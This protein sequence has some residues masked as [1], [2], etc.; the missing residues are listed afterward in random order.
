MGVPQNPKSS[1]LAMKLFQSDLYDSVKQDGNHIVSLSQPQTI[2][3]L[4]FAILRHRA[5]ELHDLY[6][7]KITLFAEPD[8]EKADERER[9]IHDHTDFVVLNLFNV[10]HVS[11]AQSECDQNTLESAL[12]AV[13][14]ALRSTH[15]VQIIIGPI[16]L[17]VAIHKLGERV[18][19]LVL[20]HAHILCVQNFSLVQNVVK[21]YKDSKLLVLMCSFIHNN[22][23]LS[24][25]DT[26]KLVRH[27]EAIFSAKWETSAD[28][29]CISRQAPSTPVEVLEFHPIGLATCDW[30]LLVDSMLKQFCDFVLDPNLDHNN[31]PLIKP[32]P[33]LG[34]DTQS[35]K[36]PLLSLVEQLVLARSC[37]SDIIY[38]VHFLGFWCSKTIVKLYLSE[39]SKLVANEE[40]V[41]ELI[42]AV[43]SILNSIYGRMDELMTI[44]SDNTSDDVAL[45]TSSKQLKTLLGAILE[46]K[47]ANKA[48]WPI[49][50][51]YVQRR[52]IA[53][54]IA[55]W[56]DKIASNNE[57]Y[58]FIRPNY[59]VGSCRKH[60]NR[61]AVDNFDLHHE[62]AVRDVRFGYCNVLVSAVVNYERCTDMPRCNL[63]ISFDPPL[64]FSEY[65]QAKGNCRYDSSKYITMVNEVMEPESKNRLSSYVNMERL[66]NKVD[67]KIEDD[68]QEADIIESLEHNYKPY[69]SHNSKNPA[70]IWKSISLINRYCSKLPSDSFTKLSPEWSVHSIEEDD[71]ISYFCEL[72]LP[73]NSPERQIIIGPKAPMKSIAMRLAA[74]SACKILHLHG[75]LDDC[76]NPITKES[77]RA[78]TSGLSTVPNKDASGGQR[79]K[80]KGRG[81]AKAHAIG[82]TKRRQCYKKS[83]AKLFSGPPIAQ[84]QPCNLY[85]FNMVLTCP[86]PDEQNRRG[87]RIVDPSETSRNFA[88][89]CNAKLPQIC[90]FPL[91]TRSGEVTIDVELVDEDFN[92]TTEQIENLR[93]FHRFTFSKVLRLEKYPVVYDPERS[94]FTVLLAPVTNE[95]PVTKID[96]EFVQKIVDSDGTL[97]VPTEEQRKAFEFKHDDYVDAVVIPWYRLT[98]RQQ[99]AYYV[100][101]ICTDL[102][103]TSAFPDEE[104]GFDTFIDYYKSKYEITIFNRDQ[105]VLDV[106]HTSARLN[107]LTPR[108]V[109]RKGRTLPSSTA[110]TRR[111]SRESLVQKQLLIPELC[112]IHP[113]PA[114][115]WRK[116]VCLP[117]IFYRLNSLYLAEDLRRRVAEEVGIGFVEP[118]KGFKW[119]TLD[120]GWSLRQ[121][122]E[123]G[124]AAE[125]KKQSKQ[126]KRGYKT[127]LEINERNKSAKKSTPNIVSHSS[128]EAKN[129][130]STEEGDFVIDHFDPSKYVIPEIPLDAP[131]NEWANLVVVSSGNRSL[132]S[133]EPTGWDQPIEQRNLFIEETH[134]EATWSDCELDFDGEITEKLAG[135][136]FGSPSRF[137]SGQSGFITG[138]TFFPTEFLGETKGESSQT[139]A[140]KHVKIEGEVF[141]EDDTCEA[142]KKFAS[143]TSKEKS[144][145][146]QT[147]FES[148]QDS[149]ASW[150]L[151]DDDEQDP[152]AL[153]EDTRGYGEWKDSKMKNRP[154]LREIFVPS[155]R[156]TSA[157][158]GTYVL[159]LWTTLQHHC[160]IDEDLDK[161]LL[162]STSDESLISRIIDEDLCPG[163]LSVYNSVHSE[164][165]TA[166]HDKI[167]KTLETWFG[168]IRSLS[169]RVD[170][171]L[172]INNDLFKHNVIELVAVDDSF[173]PYCM[174]AQPTFGELLPNRDSHTHSNCPSEDWKKI[175]FDPTMSEIKANGPGPSVILQAL[176]MSNASDGINLE[177]LE[178]VGDSFLKYSI[179]AYLHCAHPT[180]HEGKLSYLRSTEISNAN[181]YHLGRTKCLGEL[182][183]A[184]KFEPNDNWLAPGYTVAD[185]SPKSATPPTK[186]QEIDKALAESPYDLTLQHSIP[187]KSIAD[188][189]EALIGAYLTSS[190][191]RAALLFMHWLGLRV[192]PESSDHGSDQNEP[193]ARWRWLGDPPSP[194]ICMEPYFDTESSQDQD[195]VKLYMISKDE[196]RSNAEAELRRLYYANNLD[197]FERKIQYTF[198]DKAFLVQ[199]FTHNS[200]YENHVTDCH[201]RLEFLGDALLDYLITRYLFEDPRCHSPGTLTDLRSA[202]VNNTFF[203]SLAVKYQ[204]H[205]YL[206]Y[207]SDEL[208]QVIDGFVKKFRF[209]T[210]DTIT[211]G[212]TLLINEGESEYAED[213][214]VPKALGDVFESV[215]GAVYLDSGMSLDRVWEVYFRM[216]EPEIEYFS[217]NVPKSPIREL[218]ESMPQNVR[219]SPSELA[220]DRKHRVIAEVF[221]LG[222]FTG[223]G[224]NKHSAKS[225]AAKRA[226]RMLASKRHELASLNRDINIDHQ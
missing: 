72:R 43:L 9:L 105:P 30:F 10:V 221:G 199:A 226:L 204:F 225:T 29:R 117:C 129:S 161:S 143:D 209:E 131:Q 83:I 51:V 165:I 147:S 101:E 23:E 98:D 74:F 190:G 179:T 39:F 210:K 15:P 113:F 169:S 198:R 158:T 155:P 94:E 172:S 2:S 170:M 82:S 5:H 140:S 20:D 212:Y 57:T 192:L 144:G 49:A 60:R 64:Q 59:I 75:E 88:I 31:E 54:V 84:G 45:E 41:G 127:I 130:S 157:T 153:D 79:A 112:S 196:I 68:V 106:D 167:R 37:L 128:T 213:I 217:S 38:S 109:N 194:L 164:K 126:I 160:S 99:F 50:I 189:V 122:I 215:A 206:Q 208:F 193:D 168:L 24:A 202:L 220:P 191:S 3:F 156:S 182:M 6:G 25:V 214:E 135:M 102:R 8:K 36:A 77:M 35:E 89:V 181:L 17:I 22:I 203:A 119:P 186:T 173:D 136:K 185:Y 151:T 46:S 44:Y 33:E 120:F 14:D 134:D 110:K 118:P 200:F 114:S 162:Q 219:F 187:D 224:R 55:L 111:E 201:Q 180:M 67:N 11:S 97:A 69:P 100:A 4:L 58:E 28:L 139:F 62:A 104:S 90:S 78:L 138:E 7:G 183:S 12:K 107:L 142:N 216:M 21:Y 66:L 116:A 81:S 95:S 63:V 32:E 19:L 133:T 124:Q 121:V 86:L 177:R 174:N 123:S 70:T 152:S 73:V 222:R 108:Y 93:T 103:P 149:D 150:S 171:S 188:C 137:D 13:D 65:I 27:F 26:V 92:L 115:F 34:G 223:V 52:V 176:T 154:L 159:K 125:D 145:P 42:G 76:M 132:S 195:H 48:P 47:P 56:L 61:M 87:R 16:D 85:R 1:F 141:S 166:D 53:K 18:N 175:R 184:T 211:K 91:F 197:E 80:V 40:P 163:L 148:A 146:N 178:T 96:W 71:K 218:L 205:K 207:I